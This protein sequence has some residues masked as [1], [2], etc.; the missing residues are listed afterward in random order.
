MTE[1]QANKL[2]KPNFRL[3]GGLTLL[4]SISFSFYFTIILIPI[5]FF[6]RKMTK[7]S[8]YSKEYF[9]NKKTLLVIIGLIIGIVP[10]LKILFGKWN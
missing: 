1:K 9:L 2:N 8:F 5:A 7:E 3:A 10:G 4:S 6:I